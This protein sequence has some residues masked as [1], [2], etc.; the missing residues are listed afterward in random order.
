MVT[1]TRPS[2]GSGAASES[3]AHKETAD[4]A[5][6]ESQEPP[7]MTA[8]ELARERLADRWPILTIE[9]IDSTQGRMELLTALLQAKLSYAH[10]LA[11]ESIGQPLILHRPPCQ[12]ATRGWL[13]TVG[14]LALSCASLFG[15]VL[16]F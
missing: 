9:E 3:S 13:N 15:L 6:R 2:L 12:T 11:Q 14:L 5:G 7:A 1:D 10:R 8:W 16:Y 4:A